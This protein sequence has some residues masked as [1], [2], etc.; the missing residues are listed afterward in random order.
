MPVW[1]GGIVQEHLSVR[2]YAGLFD[3]SHMGRFRLHGPRARKTLDYLTPNDVSSLPPGHAQYTMLLNPSGGAVDDLIIYCLAEDDFFL[4]VNAA[5]AEKDW[6]WISCWTGKDCILELYTDRLALLALQGPASEQV[7]EKTFQT[8]LQGLP[9]FQHTGFHYGG[10]TLLIART[11]YTGEDGFEIFVPAHR[12][13]EIWERLLE[14]DENLKPAGLGA[15][16]T[17]RLEACFPLYGHELDEETSPLEVGYSWVVKFQKQDFIGR[18]ALLKKKSRGLPKSL[19]AMVMLENAVPRQG[20]RIYQQNSPLGVITSG[21]FSPT[22]HQPIALFFSPP[23]KVH[24]G[25]ILTVDIRGKMRQGQV[26]KKPFYRRRSEKG[27][28]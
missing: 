1:Y 24:P 6:N 12:A 15:R 21:T 26:V 8:S 9:S 23:E 14:K 17:L 28:S 25:D 5:N 22:L 7:M 20:F 2:N 10:E 16:D 19:Q 3:V 27:V 4:V 18:T 11:G 13:L